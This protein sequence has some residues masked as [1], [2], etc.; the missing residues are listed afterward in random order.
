MHRKVECLA[1]TIAIN[2]IGDSDVTRI[3]SSPAHRQI[4]LILANDHYSIMPNPDRRKT[5]T[6]TSK[7]KIPF[8]YQED[9]V[10]NTV[11]V[12]DGNLIRTINIPEMRKLQ[13][14]A[15]FGK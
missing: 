10:N 14:K 3:S 15:L 8:I 13:S 6:V 2:I 12:Y 4:T 11:K 5:N 9:G 7:P 1:K